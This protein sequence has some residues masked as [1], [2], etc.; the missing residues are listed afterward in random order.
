MPGKVEWRAD[1]AD[2]YE[3]R[4][5]ET[6]DLVEGLHDGFDK[7]GQAVTSTPEAQ[8]RAKAPSG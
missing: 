7:A 3:Q 5:N 2:L 1:A 6:I 8:A 4:L